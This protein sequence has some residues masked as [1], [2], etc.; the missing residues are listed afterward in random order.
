MATILYVD[1][2]P[3]IGLILED[4][5]ER[6]GHTTVGAHSVPEALQALAKGHV[7][8]IISDYRM[9]GLTGLE[10]LELLQ[11]EG[12]DVPLIML[13]G[14][15]T[16]EHAVAAIKAGAVDYITKPVRP[17]QL[18][19][20]V[21]QAL[22]V[23]RLRRENDTLRRE[24]MELRSERAIIGESVQIQRLLQTVTTAA[25]TRATVLLEGESGTGKELFARA[26]HDASDRRDRPFI[27][28]NCAALPEGLVESALFGHEKGAFTGAIKRVEG[29]FERAHLGTLLLDEVSEMRLD[30]QSKLLRVLQEQEFERVGGSSPIKVDVRIIATTNRNLATYAEQGHFRQDLFFRLSVLPISLPPLRERQGDIPLLAHR[31]A[32]RIANEIGKEVRGLAPETVEM[33]QR[34]AWPGNVRELQHAVERAVILSTDPVLQPSAFE[35]Q[36]FGLSLRGTGPVPARSLPAIASGVAAAPA[37]PEGAVV[38]TSLDV[39]DAESRLIERALAVSGGNRTRAA[40]LLGISVRTLRNKLNG[41]ARGS[42]L[43]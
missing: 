23:V 21:A 36:R 5:L 13:T 27:K 38:L 31:F 11:Q 32:V 8:L 9:P 35:A 42:A 17:E 18:E 29:A 28:L 6:A 12:Y 34:Y 10:F 33:L 24:V 16:I 7:D 40:E 15:A 1:D 3:A 30:L 39:A 20:S 26:I 19:L 41:P 2:E 37:T 14:Y 43:R 25:P 22:E 4:T